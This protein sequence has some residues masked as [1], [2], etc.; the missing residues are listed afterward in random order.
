MLPGNLSKFAKSCCLFA[1]LAALPTT[2]LADHRGGGYYDRGDRYRDYGHGGGGGRASIGISIGAASPAIVDCDPAPPRLVEE[3]AYVEPVYR[4]VTDRRWV[5]PVYR[6]VTD[7]VWVPPVVRTIPDHKWVP[8][9][10]EWRDVVTYDHYGRRRIGREY[11][12]VERG[13]FI[14]SPRTVEIAPGGWDTCAP[15]QEL[16]ST[17]HWEDCPRQELVSSG[18]W[19]TRTVA[20]AEPAPP[21][22]PVPYSHASISLRFPIGH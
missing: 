11:V 13:H 22:R 7:R 15:R 21:P 20:V 2:A 6:T 17:G 12:L 5:E 9:H 10:Y 19:T 18:Y 8:D 1:A 4:T 14:D 16:V 3:R